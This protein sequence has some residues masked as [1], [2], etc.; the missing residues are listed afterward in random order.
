[1]DLFGV[2]NQD[3]KP[4]SLGITAGEEYKQKRE[5][6]AN[7]RKFYKDLRSSQI[8]YFLMLPIFVGLLV[9]TTVLVVEG[10]IVRGFLPGRT[11]RSAVITNKTV[12]NAKS[13]DRTWKSYKISWRDLE[14]EASQEQTT[15]VLAEDWAKI[16]ENQQIKLTSGLV[17][18]EPIIIGTDRTQPTDLMIKIAGW[19]FVAG[20]VIYSLYQFKNNRKMLQT[21]VK[22]QQSDF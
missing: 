18:R 20:L 8:Y 10:L 16:Q 7:Y 12:E 11:L 6:A 21:E 2:Y 1:M 5:A 15:V 22:N 17:Y 3:E 9:F 13:T 19:L 14:D 4:A